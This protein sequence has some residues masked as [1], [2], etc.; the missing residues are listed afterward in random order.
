[1][2]CADLADRV[3][4]TCMIQLTMETVLSKQYDADAHVRCDPL[5]IDGSLLS[6]QSPSSRP[7]HQS[8]Y[9]QLDIFHAEVTLV[10]GLLV[11][12]TGTGRL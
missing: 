12:S 11:F 3:K 9:M 4:S 1:M 8:P 5:E 7:A 2:S 6:T 10:E